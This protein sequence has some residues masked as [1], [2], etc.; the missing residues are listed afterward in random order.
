[1]RY[2]LWVVDEHPLGPSTAGAVLN[3]HLSA[4]GGLP[5]SVLLP[6]RDILFPSKERSKKMKY[7]CDLCGWIY[8]EEEGYPEGG[9]A[10][11][12]KWEDVP[13]NFECPLCLVGKDLFSEA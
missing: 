8:D 3:D 13:E 1:M 5:E 10:P 6:K 7:V 4:Y 2:V 12:T 9:I 11:G